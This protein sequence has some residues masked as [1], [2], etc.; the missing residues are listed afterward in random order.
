MWNHVPAMAEAMKTQGIERPTLT[1]QELRD[2]SAFLAPATGGQA[3]GPL[4]VL[5]GRPELG[6]N[7]FSEPWVSGGARPNSPP[8]SGTKLRP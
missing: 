8:P 3:A 7:L 5:P 4:Y 1:A 2:L 6:R